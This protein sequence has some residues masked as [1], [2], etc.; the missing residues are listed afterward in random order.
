[1]TVL[2]FVQVVPKQQYE[3]SR[4]LRTRVPETLFINLAKADQEMDRIITRL[5]QWTNDKNS[6][7][8]KQL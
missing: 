7:K 4:L 3:I 5:E 1:M 6:K 8:Q 2:C